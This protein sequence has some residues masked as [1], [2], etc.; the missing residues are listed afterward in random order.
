[1]NILLKIIK[2]NIRG[3]FKLLIVNTRVAKKLAE[4]AKYL[5][6]YAKKLAE[7]AKYLAI[8]N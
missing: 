2:E 4:C 8:N 7:C 1:M 3:V 5:A 6:I